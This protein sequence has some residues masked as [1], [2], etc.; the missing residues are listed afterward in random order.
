MGETKELALSRA[1]VALMK[2]H[3]NKERAPEV[4]DT[5]LDQQAH[6]E[7]YIGKIG[8]K[9]MLD[10]NDGYAYL[11]QRDDLSR[12]EEVP[13]LVPR[14]QLSYSVS[15]LL[16]LLRKKLL[17]FDSDAEGGRLI[18][19]K[20]QIVESMKFYLKDSANETKIIAEIG[21][22][23]NRLREMGYVRHLPSTKSSEE[24]FEVQR[25]I[26]SV[27]NGEWLRN[28]D[29]KL[30][31]Y[32]RSA[33]GDDSDMGQTDMPESAAEADMANPDGAAER[34]YPDED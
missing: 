11:K 10:E 24:R 30:D 13:R 1:I 5:I 14:H 17:E 19:T 16:V 29:E 7:D 18:L 2:S 12:E 21:R 23:I 6:I 25:I 33:E 3:V 15:L 8:L 31:Q 20:D 9:L 22:D 27:V 4:W 26:R 28:F 32:I 34:G